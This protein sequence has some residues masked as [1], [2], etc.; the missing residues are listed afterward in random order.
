MPEQ[1]EHEWATIGIIVAPFGLRGELK[2]HSLTDIH[3]RFAQLSVV[4]LG[5]DHTRHRIKSVRSH[6]GS[7]VLLKLEGFEDATAAE[8]LRNCNLTI[9]LG[10][11]ATLPPDSYYQHDILGLH[12][13]TLDERE[14]G[15]I[16]DII[17]TGGNDVYTIKALDGREILIPATKETIKEVDLSQQKM[18]ITP[19][20]GLLDEQE[21]LRDDFMGDATEEERR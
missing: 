1:S 20:A 19:I 2:V 16:V 11:L 13:F 18:Y 3:N 9:P 6:K 12:V 21:A 14:I 15:I 7:M 10:Q 17:I 4:Y 8:T 5:P